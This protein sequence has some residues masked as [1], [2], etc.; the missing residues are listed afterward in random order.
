MALQSL[1][2]MKSGAKAIQAGKRDRNRDVKFVAKVAEGHLS[3]RFDYAK[4]VRDAYKVGIKKDEM[5][6]AVVGKPAPDFTATTMSGRKFK[7]SSVLKK[8][9]VILLF[10][11]AD[12]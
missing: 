3:D 5:A 2:W 11:L 10:Q 1:G 7:L 8:K 9:V 12:W 4:Q 6:T